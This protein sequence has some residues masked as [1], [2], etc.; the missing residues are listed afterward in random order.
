MF[1]KSFK[2]INLLQKRPLAVK[3]SNFEIK[4]IFNNNDYSFIII[5]SFKRNII[6]IP[7]KKFDTVSFAAKPNTTPNTPA[8][9]RMPFMLISQLKKIK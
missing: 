2:D 6:K 7:A 3:T 1:G 4:E 5:N 8:E 9:A